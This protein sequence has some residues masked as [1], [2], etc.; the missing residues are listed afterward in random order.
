MTERW[1]FSPAG[2]GTSERRASLIGRSVEMRQLDDALAKVRDDGKPRVVTVIGSTG[3]GKTR[4]VRD[5]LVKWR[6]SGQTAARVYRGTSRDHDAAYGVI[7]RLLR[8]RFGLVEGMDPDAARAQ[9]RSQLATVLE[10]RKVGD[11][12]FF[13]GQLLELE[14]PKSPLITAIETDSKQIRQVRHAVLKGFWE[15]DARSSQKEA[16][17]PPLVLVLDDLQWAH[18]ES[19]ELLAYLVDGLDARALI[20][21]VGRPELLARR[22]DWRAK[23]PGRHTLIEL[24]PLSEMD[25]SAVMHD[26]LSPC[27]DEAATEE[28]VDAACN[29]AGGNPALL[30]QMLRIYLDL[31]VLVPA[32]V[33]ELTDE[34]RWIVHLEKMDEVK[35]PL[36]V[37]DAVT[38]RIATL[39]QDERDVLERAAT[40]GSVF[41]LGG[42]VALSRLAGP[43]PAFWR[44]VDEPDIAR[45]RGTLLELRERDYI[46]ALPDST[47]TGDEEYAFKHNLEREKLVKLTPPAIARGWHATL[48]DWLSHKDNVR[49]HEEYV[50][51]LARHREKAG[52]TTQAAATWLDAADVA[53]SRYANTRAAEYYAKALELADKGAE[54]DAEARMQAAHHHGEVL[55]ALGRT[56][57]AMV[58]FRDML[59]HAYRL[60]LRAKGGAA[61]SRI[62]RLHRELGELDEAKQRLDA[63]LDLF[64]AS[65]DERGIA[66]TV[67]DLGKLAWLRGDY[68]EALEQTQRAL[69]MRRALGDT[70]SIALSL[71]NLGMVYQDSG[72]LKL[73]LDAFE[74]ALRIRREI[75]DLIGVSVS[76]NNLGTVAQDQRDDARALALFQEAYDV[77]K[78]TGDRNRLALILTNLGE[79][80]TRLGDTD[81]AV[82]FLKQAEHTAD[83]LGDRTGLAEAARGLAKAY[84]GQREYTKARECAA[85]AVDIF[86]AMGSK[87]QLGVVLRALGEVSLAGSAGGEGLKAALAQLGESIAVL[88]EAKNEV[89]LSRSLRALGAALREG[90]KAGELGPEAEKQ[91]QE[92]E[93]RAES[94]AARL[95]MSGGSSAASGPVSHGDFLLPTRS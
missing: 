54:V 52:R 24:A 39:T 13:L 70:R 65:A 93:T 42:L 7:A 32:H 94:I 91:A 36:T 35:L 59:A 38:A 8:A 51:M 3:I 58:A 12:A 73:A 33:D 20:I 28:L 63:A 80:Y 79:T 86:R 78:E 90:V 18:E 2:I 19:L 15:A 76:L 48:A 30:E 50:A 26:L 66:S 27:G 17:R 37:E 47:F 23:A 10:D 45:I 49:S 25:A 68:D 88:T 74:Q 77:A 41:W 89:E 61:H 75:G 92:H 22:D 57:E 56:E 44:G 29:L 95:K 81:R 71:N 9:I 62:G 83:E 64:E 6:V 84:L 31:G 85:R 5:F 87:V 60:D 53:R 46:I 72:H 69:T 82:R 4:L 16:S 43:V 14:F 67:D 21:A 55:Q 11:V 40:V 34:D 1:S